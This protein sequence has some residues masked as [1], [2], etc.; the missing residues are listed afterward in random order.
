MAKRLKHG[1][2][3]GGR[4]TPEYR[5]WSA[6]IARCH[7]GNAP[8]YHMYGGRGIAV[9]ERWR[10]DFVAFLADMGPRPADT[11]LDRIDGSG[12]YE[13]GNCRWADHQT[14]SRN[15]HKRWH[16]VTPEAAA[17]IRAIGRSRTLRSIGAEF[18]ISHTNV[19]HILEGSIHVG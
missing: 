5:S 6:M 4:R 17:K 19:R 11:T 12:N 1:A 14:Q 10:R 8:N 7:N 15:R 13:P 3:R 16:K 2:A 9:C 18:G